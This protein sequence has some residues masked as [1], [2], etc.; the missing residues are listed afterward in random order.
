MPGSSIPERLIFCRKSPSAL[1]SPNDRLNVEEKLL[2]FRRLL[3]TPPS[4]RSPLN[5]KVPSN[6]K[7]VAVVISN[8]TEN[9]DSELDLG[10][11]IKL[12]PVP[13]SLYEADAVAE[14]VPTIM[15]SLT[16]ELIVALAEAVFVLAV[17]DSLIDRLNI[18]DWL[19]LRSSTVQL[20]DLVALATFPLDLISES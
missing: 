17:R 16:L 12:L 15:E 5:S 9:C 19:A 8:V 20:S 11:F 14:P 6:S 3:V 13:L 2:L 10:L 4:N 18:K 7:N 1:L